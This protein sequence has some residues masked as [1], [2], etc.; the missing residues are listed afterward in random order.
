MEKEIRTIFWTGGWDSTYRMIELSRQDM[1]VQPIYVIDPERKSTAIEEAAMKKMLE[2]LRNRPETKAVLDDVIVVSPEEIPENKEIDEAFEKLVQQV[3]IG[4]Q[5]IWLAKVAQKYPG[6]EIGIEKPAGEYNGCVV[7][8]ET[9]GAF[10]QKED[11]FVLDRTKATE[12]CRLLFEN[13]SFPIAA[14]EEV[15]MVENV[16]KWGYQDIM[17]NIWFCHAPV[18][19]KPCGY[20]RPCQQKMECGMEWLLPKSAQLRYHLYKFYRDSRLQ[21]VFRKIKKGLKG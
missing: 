2:A 12:E 19:G 18:S 6:I 3:R 5:Y 8:I 15:Q 7:L 21:T 11:T 13:I 10:L 14:I 16:K 20:C 1:E 9:F 4:S 17:K